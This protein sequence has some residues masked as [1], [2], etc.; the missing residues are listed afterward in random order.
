MTPVKPNTEILTAA[1]VSENHRIGRNHS[2]ALEPRRHQQR[3]QDDA[4]ARGAADH[5]AISDGADRK[6]PLTDPDPVLAQQPPERHAQDQHA[7]D[8]QRRAG[9]GQPCIAVGAERRGEQR[10]RD[11]DDCLAAVGKPDEG[12]EAAGIG[13][14]RRDRDDRH[15]RLG[16][17]HRHQHQRHQGAGAIAGKTADHGSKQRNGCDKQNLQERDICEAG[18]EIQSR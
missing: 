10:R 15:D 8:H 18:E 11:H 17:D 16:A 12:N 1:L 5:D 6:A 9:T 3:Q 2:G 13:E 4:R 14:D 7:P